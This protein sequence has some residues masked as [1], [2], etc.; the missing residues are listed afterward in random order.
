MAS[1]SKNPGK[2]SPPASSA[3]GGPRTATRYASS[4]PPPAAE[5]QKKKRFGRR[6]A[7]P[8]AAAGEKKP[9]FARL[10][11][12]W[13]VFTVT[14]KT[15]TNL[16][17]ILLA[18][19]LGVLAIAVVVGILTDQIV[20][21]VVLGVPVGFLIAL[22]VFTRRAEKNMYAQMEGMTGSSYQALSS[23]KR[24]WSVE[25]E[26]AAMDGRTKDMVFRAIGRPGIVL[27]GEGPQPRIR[28][29][30]DGEQRKVSRVASGVPIHTI[31]VGKNEGEVPLR[32][33]VREMN[34]LKKQLTKNELN[35]VSRRVR[36]LKGIRS[37]IPKGVD[38][39]RARPNRKAMKG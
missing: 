37:G 30:L 34:K 27:V 22:I 4:T 35:E 14:K 13:Q 33:L 28:R 19:F 15:D 32:R 31:I 17:W 11:Q 3:P 26:P 5:A 6:R 21:F 16:P 10:R 12:I 9:R 39:M 38:P 23:I 25:E 36:T 1:T 7:K 24:G 29:L 8:V 2:S 18:I 20:Y